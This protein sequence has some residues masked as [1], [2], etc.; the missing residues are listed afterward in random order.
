MLGGFSAT[1][2]SQAGQSKKSQRARGRNGGDR[3]FGHEDVSRDDL[4]STGIESSQ[5][6]ASRAAPG[7]KF[8]TKS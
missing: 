1:P 2:S 7:K 3:P 6:A 5:G 8:R 4:A